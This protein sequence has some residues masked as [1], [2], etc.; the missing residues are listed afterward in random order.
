LKTRDGENSLEEKEGL[1]SDDFENVKK[2]KGNIFPGKYF[3][4]PGFA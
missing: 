1:G 3:T 4:Q 2:A